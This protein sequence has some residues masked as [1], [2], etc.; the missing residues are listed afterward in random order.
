[1]IIAIDETGDFKTNLSKYNLFVAVHIRQLNEL[2]K[3]KEN[4]FLCWEKSLPKSL[5]NYKGEIKSEKLS[6]DDLEVFVDKII[7]SEPWIGITPTCLITKDNPEN[8]VNIHKMSQLV[9]LNDG[10][11]FYAKQGKNK[12]SRQWR[13]FRN[14]FNNL[15]YSAYLKTNLLGYCI[16]YSFGNAIGTSVACNFEDELK[17]ICYKIDRDSIKDRMHK[18]FW[19]ILLK[20]QLISITKT[21]RIPYLEKWQKDGSPFFQSFYKNGLFYPG[22]LFD[23]RCDFLDSHNTYEIRIAD[24]V[25]TIINRYLNYNS[26]QAAYCRMNRYILNKHIINKITL[27]EDIELSHFFEIQQDNLWEYS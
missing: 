2:N 21:I 4:Q 20:N 12:L 27:K 25:S 8:I 24:T 26:C 13:D 6:D 18:V 9:G 17:Y 15:S 22:P 19:T 16:A 14:W 1:M 5:K 3:I 23:E 7:L 11:L 10:I